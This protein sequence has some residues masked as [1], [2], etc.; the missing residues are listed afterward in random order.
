MSVLY[1]DVG[2]VLYLGS[3]DSVPTHRCVVPIFAAGLDRDFE[4]CVTNTSSTSEVKEYRKSARC[5]WA[6]AGVARSVQG[7]GG[8]MGVMLIDPGL[9]CFLEL[10]ETVLLNALEALRDGFDLRAW[11]ALTVALGLPS[12]A[13]SLLPKVRQAAKI[14]MENSAENIGADEIAMKVGLSV[15][16]LEHLFTKTM[17]TPLRSYRQWQRFRSAAQSLAD[18]G[19]LTLAAHTAGFYDSAHFNHAFNL[20]FGLSPSQIFRSDLKIIVVPSALE[21]ADSY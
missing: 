2:K 5:Q 13:Q 4:V 6:K 1:I 16:R 11:Q 20:S 19:S 21:G 8:V 18:G 14:I 7:F 17:G 12:P 10:K 3:V 9:P 15:S